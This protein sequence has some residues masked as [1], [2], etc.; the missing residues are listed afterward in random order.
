M[1]ASPSKPTMWSSDHIVGCWHHAYGEYQ[2]F[3]AKRMPSCL[4][5]ASDG[6]SDAAGLR[7]QE[8]KIMTLRTDT[9]SV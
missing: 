9:M 4:K 7:T 2:T 8:G 6:C 3:L 5:T 1:A